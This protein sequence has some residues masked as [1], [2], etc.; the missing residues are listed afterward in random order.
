MFKIAERA[1][2][3]DAWIRGGIRRLD[4]KRLA[5]EG[6]GDAEAL[7]R[8][9]HGFIAQLRKSP[10]ALQTDKPREQHYEMPPEFFRF[11]LGLR[12]FTGQAMVSAMAHLFRGLRRAL[13]ICRGTGMVGLPLPA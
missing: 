7:Q 12:P 6:K 1:L 4:R 2:I 9:K 10:I 11:V 8:A 3:P 13:G 5:A